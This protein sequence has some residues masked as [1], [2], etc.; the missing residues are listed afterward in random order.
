MTWKKIIRILSIIILVSVLVSFIISVAFCVVLREVGVVWFF[1]GEFINEVL[2]V[3]GA[4]LALLGTRSPI[5]REYWLIPTTV[6][7]L[8]GPFLGETLTDIASLDLEKESDIDEI[9]ASKDYRR[10]VIIIFFILSPIRRLLIVVTGVYTACAS[11]KNCPLYNTIE[12]F[13]DDDE[14]VRDGEIDSVLDFVVI[15]TSYRA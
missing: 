9:M 13:R 6:L 8:V 7:F 3:I 14:S 5:G 12:G 11:C 2:Y 10:I 15:G 4:V 1:A